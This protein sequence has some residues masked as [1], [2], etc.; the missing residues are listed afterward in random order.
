MDFSYVPERLRK[1]LQQ[2]C[3]RIAEI[4][5]LKQGSV[6]IHCY[7][8][9]PKGVSVHDKSIKFEESTNEDQDNS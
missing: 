5:H 9:E 7:R 6:E 1:E 8:G 4:L 3:G 2:C